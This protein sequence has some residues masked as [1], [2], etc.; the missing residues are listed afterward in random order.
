MD[1]YPPQVL[2]KN[3]LLDRI[4]KTSRSVFLYSSASFAILIPLALASHKIA[5]LT[6]ELAEILAITWFS[7]FIIWIISIFLSSK[8]KNIFIRLFKTKSEKTNLFGYI[9]LLLWFICLFVLVSL[10]QYKLI[11]K[12]DTSLS[13]QKFIVFTL[14]IATIVLLPTAGIMINNR[15]I[16]SVIFTFFS[17]VIVLLFIVRFVVSPSKVR[18]NSMSPNILNGQYLLYNRMAYNIYNPDRGD[19]V[20]YKL[21]TDGK[22]SDYIARIIGIS[23]DK[24]FIKDGNIYINGKLLHEPYLDTNI[25]TLEGY[26]INENEVIIPT[27]QYV[28]LGDNRSHSSDSRRYGTINKSNIKGKV[29]YSYWPKNKIGPIKT[30]KT[31]L[32]RLDI[33]K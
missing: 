28:V 8:I 3:N 31:V 1:V 14:S 30:S 6:T 25:Q 23:G 15:I 16:K 22:V 7:S 9:I 24:I 20:I 33:E 2:S 11:E 32:T 4:K 27:G 12:I 17:L 5:E 10:I 21:S 18:G 26:M 29:I 13:L 19:I